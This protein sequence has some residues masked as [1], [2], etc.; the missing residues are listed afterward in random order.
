MMTALTQGL[1]NGLQ[2]VLHAVA[3]GGGNAHNVFPGWNIL[4]ADQVCL[5]V[6]PQ[7]LGAGLGKLADQAVHHLDMLLPVGVG[8]VDHMQQ[9]IC[10]FQLLQGRPERIHQMVRK[11][12]NKA[13]GVRQDHIQVVGY[14][15][16]AGG[17]I[18]GIKEAVV[19]RNACAGELIEQCRFAG[20]GVAHDGHHRHGIFHAPFPLHATDLA[21][22]LQLR[23]QS[24]DPLPDVPAVAFQLGFAGAPGT[25]A[26]ALPGKALAH[27]GQPGQQIFILGQL[28]LQAAFLGLGPLGENI[29]NQ[30]AAVQHRYPQDLL[31]GTDMAGRQF[32]VKDHHARLGKLGQH[33]HFL[34][35]ALAD[36][37]VG[38]GGVAILQDLAGAETARR[39]KQ[40]FQLFQGLLRGGL[41]F[42]KAVCVQAYQHRPLLLGF[43]IRFHDSSV[44]IGNL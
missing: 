18:Q 14:G 7:D 8:G 26:A 17:G 36:E 16:L 33:S 44:E 34:G 15:Q 4:P 22:L 30:S 27:T 11:L 43:K 32:V 24:G 29:Q 37:A 20:V 28:H 25:D 41:F 3:L 9:K 6:K 40:C 23:L 2:Q 19:G 35:L 42:C 5:V 31:Q 10:V 13:H 12:C 39:F 21:H 38:I 1:F